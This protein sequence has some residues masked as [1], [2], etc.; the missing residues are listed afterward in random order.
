MGNDLKKLNCL[1]KNNVQ[2]IRKKMQCLVNKCSIQSINKG[3]LT[4]I[5]HNNLT[6]SINVCANGLCLN[7]LN[8]LI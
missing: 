4:F 6:K 2:S 3:K 1:E 8:Y 5:I 7:F